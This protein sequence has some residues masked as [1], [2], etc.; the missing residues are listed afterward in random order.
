MISLSLGLK[1]ESGYP[2]GGALFVFSAQ[3]WLPLCRA[4]LTTHADRVLFPPFPGSA[5]FAPRGQ[6]DEELTHL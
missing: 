6:R 3:H 4:P 5:G 2:A 1:N